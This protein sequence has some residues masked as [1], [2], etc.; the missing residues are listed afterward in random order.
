MDGA[1]ADG[2]GA[3]A[4]KQDFGTSGRQLA[5]HSTSVCAEYKVG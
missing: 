5:D 3:A 2:I 1:P 4:C